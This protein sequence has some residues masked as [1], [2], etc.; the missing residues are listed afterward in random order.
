MRVSIP[1]WLKSKPELGPL[2]SFLCIFT[3]F[4]LFAPKFLTIGSITSI[5]NMSAEFGIVVVGVTLLMTGGEF[6]LSVGAAFAL[7]NFVFIYSTLQN[8]PILLGF[9]LAISCGVIIG[10]INGWITT[11][12]AVPSL[13]VT[14]GM[15]WGVRG[16]LLFFA[17]RRWWTIHAIQSTFFDVLNGKTFGLYN[18]IF[19]FLALLVIGHIILENTR[20]GNQI[21]ACGGDKVNARFM[22]VNVNKLKMLTFML[23]GGLAAF[24]GTANLSRFGYF[25]WYLGVG[26]ELEVIAAVVLGGTLLMGGYGTLIGSLIGVLLLSTLRNGMILLGV[27]GYWYEGVIG[28]FLIIAM[29]LNIRLRPKIQ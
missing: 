9:I 29:V 18:A 25:H 24:A 13:I 7:G 16:L 6:D 28:A 12:F 15:L 14:I 8:F 11:K 17:A 21:R 27:P 10:A 3:F 22:G 5:L 19:W 26:M 23:T 2:V 1:I 4:G 20:F